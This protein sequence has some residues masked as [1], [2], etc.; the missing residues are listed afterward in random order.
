M[1]KINIQ[2][3]A[4]TAIIAALYAALTWLLA[5]IS[6]GAVQFRISEILV[7]LVVFKPSYCVALILGCFIA[8][9]TSSLGWWDMVFG[10]LATAVAV[11]PMMKIKK[12][13][14]AATLP[15]I[16]NGIIVAIELYFALNIEPIWLSM[17]TVALGEA[18]VLYCIGIPVMISISKNEVLV[19]R[20]G[21]KV[22][23][24]QAPKVFTLANALA[25]AVAILGV[26]LFI[27]YPLYS[28]TEITE[29]ETVKTYYSALTMVKSNP[30]TVLFAIAPF[31]YG[32]CFLVFKNKIKLISC[33][34]S[35][36]LA[37]AVFIATG[38]I[39]R[40]T[41]S[42]GYYYGYIVYILMLT[43]VFVY[44]YHRESKEIE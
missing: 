13:W 21:L 32:V 44:G 26:V 36:L 23:Q 27:A 34:L 11:L 7:L 37:I 1:K 19:E 39:Y 24:V 30:W 42:C 25:I 40:E 14:L 29:G 6:Y 17:L 16:S 2:W 28:G 33:L 4:Q 9:T 5:P 10:T 35:V 22:E 38:V 18:V 15:V 31:L 8:N 41:L 20:L 12:L 3:V 43:A